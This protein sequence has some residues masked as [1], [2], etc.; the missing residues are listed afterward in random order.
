MEALAPGPG[1]PGT[2]GLVHALLATLIAVAPVA[3]GDEQRVLELENGDRVDYALRMHPADAHR[4]DAGARLAPTS[5]INTAKLLTR[6]LAEGRLED[7]ALLS[8]SPKARFARLRESFEG[9]SEGDFKRAYGRYFA[10]ENRIVGEV[11]IDAHRLLM[12]Y[13]SDTDYVTG[14]FLVEIDGK[15]LLDDVPNRTRANLQRVLE[16]Y[17]SGRAR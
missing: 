17:R 6:Y 4:L 14:F 10:P 15:L 1:F 7:A 9:W 5:A 12:W 8:N 3:R 13:L 2:R 11:A 16:A